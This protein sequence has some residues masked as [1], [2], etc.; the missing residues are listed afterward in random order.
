MA[1]FAAKMGAARLRRM[2][3]RINNWAGETG[4]ANCQPAAR[5]PPGGQRP[6]CPSRAEAL[7]NVSALAWPN[8]CAIRFG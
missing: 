1:H 4:V 2:W 7:S 8:R 3:P 5:G 6:A